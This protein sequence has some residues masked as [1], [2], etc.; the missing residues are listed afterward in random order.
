MSTFDSYFK[1]TTF[2]DD[3]KGFA[4]VSDDGS[5]RVL[6]RPHDGWAADGW[7]AFAVF[8]VLGRPGDQRIYLVRETSEGGAKRAALAF[9][10]SI[11]FTPKT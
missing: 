8:D 9:I 6:V 10:N 3:E 5:V 7:T 2:T 4:A 1:P 11:K